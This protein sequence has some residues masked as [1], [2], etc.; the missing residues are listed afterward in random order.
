[1]S[2]VRLTPAQQRVLRAV[3]VGEFAWRKWPYRVD[4]ELYDLQAGVKVRD[5]TASGLAHRGLLT[6]P[7]RIPF[8]S[9]MW[10]PRPAELT[11]AGRQW[12]ADH[13]PGRRMNP[14]RLSPAQEQ[15]LRRIVD[16]SVPPVWCPSRSL[17]VLK[18]LGLVCDTHEGYE[19]TFNGRRWLADH[20]EES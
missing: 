14:G 10:P 15:T 13:P 20:P 4:A 19:L 18:R 9:E 5:S 3:N 17:L 16:P 8:M 11:A 1:V 12:L 2:D 7:G 6:R